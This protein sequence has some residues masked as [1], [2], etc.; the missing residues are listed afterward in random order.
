VG[1]RIIHVNREKKE[2]AQ[3]KE[4]ENTSYEDGTRQKLA[5]GL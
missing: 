3:T 5:Y 4:W 1:D 2:F